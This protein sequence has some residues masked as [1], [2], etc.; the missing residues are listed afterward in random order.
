MRFYLGVGRYTPNDAVAGEMAWKPT[1]VRQWK[2]VGLYWS[3]LAAMENSRLNKRISLWAYEKSGRSCKNWMYLVSEFLV[4]NH[5]EQYS[6][7]TV[8]IPSS[9][10]FVAD[11]ENT[12]YENFVTNWS[13]RINSNVGTSGRGRN[14]LR[15]YKTFKQ[16][17]IVENYCKIILPVRHRAAFSKFRCGVAPIRIE[18]GRYEGL[19][20]EARLC[21]FCNVLENEMHV[22]MNCRVYDDLREPLLAKAVNCNPT[23]NSLSEVNQFVFLFSSPDLVRI[24]AKTCAKI[25]QRRHTLTCK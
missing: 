18:T 12:I 5:F 9:R 17:Y 16:S 13:A 2:S 1:S 15:S 7:I 25:L 19:P 8:A 14:K 23:F 21:P 24:C 10:R 4:A 3:K 11:F 6:N 20:E 22:I